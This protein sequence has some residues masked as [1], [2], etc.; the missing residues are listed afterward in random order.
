MTFLAALRCNGV[1]AP[2]VLD[3]PI[4]GEFFRAWVDQQLV[5]TLL[6]GDIVIMDNEERMQVGKPQGQSHS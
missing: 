3:G 2:Y 5:P 4:N 1:T 6:P